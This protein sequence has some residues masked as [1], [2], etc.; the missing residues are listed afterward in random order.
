MIALR[1]FENKIVGKVQKGKVLSERVLKNLDVKSLKAAG[2]IGDIE[3]KEPA[4]KK[5]AKK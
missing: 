1:D 5:G 3:K 2:F 4:K